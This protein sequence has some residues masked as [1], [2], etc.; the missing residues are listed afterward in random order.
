[1]TIYPNEEAH[2]PATVTGPRRA[3]V[4]ATGV[5]AGTLALAAGCGSSAANSGGS[6]ASHHP[7]A[8]ASSHPMAES[9]AFGPDCGMIPS[10]GMGSL[11]SMSMD[12][13]VAAASHNP[14]LSTF[15]SDVKTARLAGDLT[16]MHALTI[17][18]P[19]NSAFR[20]IPAAQMS[21]M[22]NAPE[23]AKILKGHVV[24]GRVTPAELAHGMTLTTLAGT[25]LRTARMGSVYEVGSA[26]V[27][28]GNI[29]TANATV[30]V[31][32]KVLEPMH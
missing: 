17:F 16:S 24:D 9:A 6:A 12:S 21:M 14:L 29:H 23:L 20:K 1:M 31:I 22:H 18:A 15:A 19:A 13:V 27:L 7:M 10:S 28:C 25:S 32:D 26:H 11:H 4:I 8:H 30:Y 2:M 5:L 3:R